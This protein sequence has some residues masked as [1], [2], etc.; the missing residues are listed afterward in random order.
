MPKS[1]SIA[2]FLLLLLCCTSLVVRAE[3]QVVINIPAFTLHL[4]D[5]GVQIKSYPIAIGTELNPSVLAETTIINMVTNPTYYP[6]NGSVK[7]L[8]PIPPGPENPVGTRWLGLGLP[9]YGIHGTN[10]PKSIGS[11]ASSGCIRMYNEDVEELA[12]LVE[13]GTSVQLIYQTVVLQ[14]DPLL[15]TRTITV[16]PDVYKQGVTPSQLGAELA[17]HNWGEVFWPALLTLLRLPAGRPQPLPWA[18]PLY[19]EDEPLDLVGVEWGERLYVPWDLPLDPRLEFINQVVQWGDQYF[20]P[21]ESYLRLTGFSHSKAQGAWIFRRPLA[22]LG[23]IP[24][25]KAL[26]FNNEIYISCLH[27]EHRFVPQSVSVLIQW[28]E[29]YYPASLF[30]Q[31]DPNQEVSLHWPEDTQFSY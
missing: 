16:F 14:E 23:E 9:G 5:H 29:V 21:L 26:V 13:V 20:L 8:E 4:Y 7:G 31:V 1:R 18:V 30:R 28:G 27:L 12:E 3:V 19:F 25:G 11:A 10:N 15:H 17:R 2:V 24:L 22:V 6:P